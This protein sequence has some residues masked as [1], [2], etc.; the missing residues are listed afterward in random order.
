VS[1]A[2]TPAPAPAPR[3]APWAGRILTGLVTAFMLFDAAIKLIKI[4]PVTD[5][6]AQLGYPDSLA[7]G[8]GALEL[9]ITV[10]YAFPRTAVLG[11]IL[12]TGIM[13]GATASHL[14]LGDPLF[15]HTLFGVY[16]GVMAWG[17]LC[18]RDPKL[19]ALLPITRA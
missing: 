9:A 4:Q 10:L 17:G 3:V 12:L 13:G 16:L 6:F 5:S 15:S 19:R 11:A 18:L 14:R 1:A 7:R 8:I 2:A